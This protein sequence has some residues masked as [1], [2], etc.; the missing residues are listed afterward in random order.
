M[1]GN[2]QELMPADITD[3]RRALAYGYGRISGETPLVNGNVMGS[4]SYYA[5]SLFA[6][7]YSFVN[8]EII[9]PRDTS[10]FKAAS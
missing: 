6:S 9:P 10:V 8:S 2:F 5:S 1:C 3:S 4:T 7:D